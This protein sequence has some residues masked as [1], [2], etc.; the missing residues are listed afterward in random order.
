MAL[1]RLQ[2]NVYERS[3]DLSHHDDQ[4][5]LQ[6]DMMVPDEA[7]CWS[8][9]VAGQCLGILAAAAL[10]RQQHLHQPR[11]VLRSYDAA[12]PFVNVR[13]QAV[14]CPVCKP[15]PHAV[16]WSGRLTM[17][18][19]AHVLQHVMPELEHPGS[20]NNTKQHQALQHASS[21]F[22]LQKTTWLAPHQLCIM[23]HLG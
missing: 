2:L 23:Q 21:Q 5:A 13:R 1:T 6:D 18:R 20:Q 12:R 22:M 15:H 7:R 17:C 11:S 19:P 8:Q 16:L 4:T 10:K 3:H 14:C 9:H